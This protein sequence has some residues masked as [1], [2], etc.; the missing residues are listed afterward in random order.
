MLCLSGFELYSRW[1][2]L[3]FDRQQERTSHK[4]A[5]NLGQNADSN[6]SI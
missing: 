5:M 2:P 1:V 4:N 6:K 3:Y